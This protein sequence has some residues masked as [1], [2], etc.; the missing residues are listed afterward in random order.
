[1]G[2][3]FL[4]GALGHRHIRMGHDQPPVVQ[5]A[6]SDQSIIRRRIHPNHKVVV[7]FDRVNHP[8]IRDDLEL[9]VRIGEGET[10]GNPAKRLWS[11]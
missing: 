5:K 10:G 11:G 7:I 9:H 2:S 4:V 8:I 1:M 3:F 6:V